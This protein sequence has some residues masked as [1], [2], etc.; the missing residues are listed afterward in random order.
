MAITKMMNIKTQSNLY[1]AIAYIMREEKTEE[2]LWIG[3][4]AGDNPEEV[5]RVMMQTK[6]DWGKLN[7]R[8]G[9]HFV[10]SWKPGECDPEKAY[11]VLQ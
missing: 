7:G 9:Y 8:K 4:N 5:Y 1:N 2:S 11:Q 10:I 6:Q 3:G